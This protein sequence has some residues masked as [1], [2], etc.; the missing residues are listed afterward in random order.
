M[1][2][3]PAIGSAPESTHLFDYIR[4]VMK[5]LWMIVVIF[6]LVLGAVGVASLCVS[7]YLLGT[8]QREKDALGGEVERILKM[9]DAVMLLVDA[10]EG[11]MPQT[12][13]VL[14]KALAAHLPAVVVI[15]KVDREGARP[16][17]VLDQTFELFDQLGASDEQLEF[18]LLYAV[19]RDGI[20]RRTLDVV[21]H[22]A[23]PDIFKLRIDRKPQTP[24]EFDEADYL[25]AVISYYTT[26][27]GKLLGTLG[28]SKDIT[29][30]KELQI[31]LV[32]A[33]Q[34]APVEDVEGGLDVLLGRVVGPDHDDDAVA[35]LGHGH[36][37][38]YGD[39][40]LRRHRPEHGRQ[41]R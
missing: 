3:K 34:A 8:L 40:Q 31:Q 21:G 22:Y 5:R 33:E 7:A 29:V 39:D 19:G 2:Q 10:S 17:W 13:Y 23:R 35:E 12:R 27:D 1:V 16:D 24:V 32:Q 41:R 11:P 30:E 28:I 9:V 18:P 25:P 37:F 4:V 6:I 20:A 14:S 26:T 15:N 38:E 36:P